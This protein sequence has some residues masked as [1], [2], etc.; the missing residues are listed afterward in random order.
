MH[1]KGQV[2]LSSFVL[3]PMTAISAN[4]Y[5]KLKKFQQKD[6]RRVETRRKIV[7]SENFIS[8]LY[9][10]IAIMVIS[11]TGQKDW[12]LTCFAFDRIPYNIL[13]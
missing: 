3:D 9:F 7:N 12:R 1:E 10:Y 11:S 5:S 8:K 2:D 13:S 6:R 4:N